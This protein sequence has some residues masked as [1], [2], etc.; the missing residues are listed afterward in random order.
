MRCNMDGSGDALD[1]RNKRERRRVFIL[2]ACTLALSCPTLLMAQS[3]TVGST[4]SQ[5]LSLSKALDALRISAAKNGG[6]RVI[7]SL[8]SAE[9]AA[10]SSALTEAAKRQFIARFQ[11][12]EAPTVQSIEGTP[13][14]VLELT[15]KG[16]ERLAA[17]PA[18]KSVQQDSPER[19]Q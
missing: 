11:G 10:E 5:N 13:Y 6:V 18:V 8:D 16:V 12:P 19:T 1:P 17:D 2:V 15:L 7:V 3:V 14:V 9:R 4:N